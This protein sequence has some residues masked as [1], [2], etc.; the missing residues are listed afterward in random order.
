M[1]GT[2]VWPATAATLFFLILWGEVVKQLGPE[3]S[4]NPQYGYGWSVPFLSLYLIW[5]RWT[6][7]PPATPPQTRLLPIALIIFCALLLFPIRFLAETNPD[8][9]LLDWAMAFTA[10]V[11]SLGLA[12]LIG[13]L[14]WARHFAFPICFFLVAVPLPIRFE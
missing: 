6:Q 10:V 11:I 7:R 3:W 4:F 14:S 12:F 8:W 5:Q 2:T 13:G 1:F 9:L